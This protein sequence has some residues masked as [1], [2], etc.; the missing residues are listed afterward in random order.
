MKV[1]RYVMMAVVILA[2]S[3]VAHAI[4]F[5]VLDPAGSQGSLPPIDTSGSNPFSF[6]TCTVFPAE[7]GCFGAFNG[8][9]N[10][11]TSFSATIKA[12]P[13]VDL[14]SLDCPTEASDGLPS[15]FTDAPTCNL[16]GDIST[17]EIITVTFDGGPGVVPGHNIWIVET[18]ID[19]AGFDANAG[20][21]AVTTTTPE[22]SSIWLAL[23]GLGP[24]GYA[25]R[26]RRR[27]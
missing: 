16:S 26:R 23:T 6:Y 3:G 9:P 21:F 18:E 17:G 25:L 15:A 20:S 27:V 1:F 7:K 12:N 13:G 2:M 24:F 4:T 8:S 5:K 19:P 14:G 11:I 22:P 10:T